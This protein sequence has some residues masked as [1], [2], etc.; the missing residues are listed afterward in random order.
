MPAVSTSKTSKPIPAGPDP[1][2]PRQRLDPRLS[3]YE[4]KATRATEC[5][6]RLDLIQNLKQSQLS[7]LPNASMIDTQ[8]EI[9]WMMRPYLLDFLIDTHLTLN[10]APATLFLAV[11]LVDRYCS[12]RIVALKHYQL[13]GCASL[14]L[15][16]KYEDKKSRVPQLKELEQVSCGSYEESMFLQMEGHILNTIEW[17]VGHA[18]VE[19]FLQLL[20]GS[21]C[22]PTLASIAQYLAE[23]SMYHRDFFAF[24][25][26]TIAACCVALASHIMT[27]ASTSHTPIERR[28]LASAVAAVAAIDDSFD[29]DFDDSIDVAVAGSTD[30]DA[31]PLELLNSPV[32]LNFLQASASNSIHVLPF[33]SMPNA[34]EF[35]CI[36][37]LNTHMATPTNNL[38][39]KFMKSA[40]HHVPCIVAEFIQVRYELAN[41][42][43]PPSPPPFENESTTQSDSSSSE[44]AK[45]SITRI[46]LPKAPNQGYMTPPRTPSPESLQQKSDQTKYATKVRIQHA[47]SVY[48]KPERQQE[49]NIPASRITETSASD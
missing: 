40:F 30:N 26:S 44:P 25:P 38:Q 19:S 5:E 37:L 49:F 3:H 4:A 39:K 14:W 6:Y 28:R 35:Q 11:N 29:F 23:V 46:Q 48:T 34:P 27:F 7:T 24:T 15:A 13:V 8:P 45:P 9:K 20:L 47:T 42:A 33:S 32:Y 21:K 36:S 2:I 10:L 1:R 22:N 31:L 43:L 41:I 12:R 18:S 16:S 17:S